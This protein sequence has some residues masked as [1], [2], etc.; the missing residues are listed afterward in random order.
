METRPPRVLGGPHSPMPSCRFLALVSALL[1]AFATA[2]ANAAP[3]PAPEAKR[4]FDVPA[5]DATQTLARFAEQAERE[6]VFSPTTVRGVQTN[7]VR[8]D[9]SPREALDLLV[10]RTPLVVTRDVTTGA[11]ADRKSVV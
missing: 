10:A 6:I 4:R 5:G 9:F 1:L 7:P 8:G 11:L 3:S 2:P